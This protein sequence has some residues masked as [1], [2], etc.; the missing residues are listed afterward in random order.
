M[1]V[2]L[3]LVCK[4]CRHAFELTTDY[5]VPEDAKRCPQCGSESIRQTFAS[6]LRNGSILN[7]DSYDSRG[8]QTYG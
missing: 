2:R 3:S 4:K 1:N 8:C 6:Y 5:P 7:P